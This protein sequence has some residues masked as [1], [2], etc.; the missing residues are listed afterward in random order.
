MGALAK[1]TDNKWE[2]WSKIHKRN[3]RYGQ[4]YPNKFETL[5]RYTKEM[6]EK[7]AQRDLVQDTPN[8]WEKVSK[9]PS[10]M[11]DIV[12]DTKENYEIWSGK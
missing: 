2:N 9:I 10:E 11:G 7:I 4:R 1:D 3:G 5:S 12:K 6:G 8:I